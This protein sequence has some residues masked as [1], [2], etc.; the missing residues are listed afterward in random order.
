MTLESLKNAW[1]LTGS[2]LQALLGRL[3]PDAER[4]G[5]KYEA[6]RRRLAWFFEIR[7]SFQPEEHADETLNRMTRR[8]EAGEAIENLT[9]YAHGVARL[10]LLEALRRQ[11]RQRAGEIAFAAL[12]HSATPEADPRCACLE[13]CLGP[14]PLQDRELVLQYYGDDDAR[15]DVRRAL[16]E[17]LGITPN[18]LRGRVFRIR[19]RLVDCVRRCVA[20]GRNATTLSDGRDKGAARQETHGPQG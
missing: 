7:G 2:A 19:E 14:L 9:A 16:A 5:E 20:E 11:E 17:R 8:I 1:S 15:M 10:V 3:D 6:L 18:V 4:A 12:S 13:A